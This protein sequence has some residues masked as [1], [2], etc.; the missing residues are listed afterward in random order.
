MLRT[1]EQETV[2]SS[3][4]SVVKKI[5]FSAC[6]PTQFQFRNRQ[7]FPSLLEEKDGLPLALEDL[8]P[9]LGRVPCD[10]MAVGPQTS[11]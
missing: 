6:S 8:S 2:Y 4:G 7:N 5:P 3:A 1:F 10:E 11:S 9:G